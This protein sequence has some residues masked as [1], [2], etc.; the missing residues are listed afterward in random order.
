MEPIPAVRGGTVLRVLHGLAGGEPPPVRHGGSC[1]GGGAPR[2][3]PG[4]PVGPGGR[5]GAGGAR[6]GCGGE[7][8]RRPAVV[9]SGRLGRR[10]T[11][12]GG[13]P[14]GGPRGAAPRPGGGGGGG[15]GAP[16]GT[17]HELPEDTVRRWYAEMLLALERRGVPK[18]PTTTPS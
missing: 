10:G 3:G 14:P 5:G 17:R 15:G 11:C 2:G 9:G 4:G 6:G 18:A 7:A 1:P 12:W 13:P 16:R 8:R